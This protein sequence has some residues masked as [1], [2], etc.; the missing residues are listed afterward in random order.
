MTTVLAIALA[1]C[2]HAPS[3][4]APD[5]VLERTV[6]TLDIAAGAAVLAGTGDI[7]SCD[8]L[9]GAA[10][11]AAIVSAVIEHAPGALVFT[12]GDHAYPSGTAEEFQKC[13]EPTWGAFNERTVPTPG[14]HDY[15]TPNASGYFDYFA[16]FRQRPEAR[17]GGYYALEHGVWRIVVLNSLLPLDEGTEQL[18]WADA[19]LANDPAECL[20]AIWHHPLRSSGFHGWLPW[21]RGR[22]TDVLWRA[23]APHGVDVILNGHDHVYERFAIVD[24]DGRTDPDGARQFTVGTGGAELH[25]VI[26]RRRHSEYLT[27][28]TYGVLVLM[29]RD[30]GYEWAFVGTDGVVHDVSDAPVPC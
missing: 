5:R 23:L 12:T 22:D 24:T 9:D 2:G 20:L 29:L 17:R 18:E 10:A 25:P 15:E 3:F 28:D 4:I 8:M 19:L 6:G 16:V 21:D 7:A 14:N 27:N 26:G 13:Y 11:T 30:G 1:G